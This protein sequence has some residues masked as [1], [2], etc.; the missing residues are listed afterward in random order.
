MF[1]TDSHSHQQWVREP[2]SPQRLNDLKGAW[3]FNPE[4]PLAGT[5]PAPQSA[6]SFV[7]QEFTPWLRQKDQ[8]T[9]E[10]KFTEVKVLK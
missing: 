6:Q 7:L 1:N 5:C 3:E 2:L 8:W 9:E 4:I 10:L